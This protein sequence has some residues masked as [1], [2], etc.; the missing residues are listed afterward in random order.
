M[1]KEKLNA[2]F[3]KFVN[4]GICRDAQQ[5]LRSLIHTAFVAGWCAARDPNGPDSEVHLFR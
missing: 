2:A 4:T 3:E 1:E 5:D